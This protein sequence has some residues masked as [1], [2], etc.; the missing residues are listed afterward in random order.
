MPSGG[1]ARLRLPMPPGTAAPELGYLEFA[2]WAGGGQQLLLAREAQGDGRY[3]RSFEV[4][5]L[6]TLVV[7]R[8]A[9][10][11]SLLAAFRRS[12]DPAW[13]AMTVSLRQVSSPGRP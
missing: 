8:Q 12:Q 2:G 13:K 6:D 3:R 1:G 5:R 9:S 10:S 11:P 7:D 4:L